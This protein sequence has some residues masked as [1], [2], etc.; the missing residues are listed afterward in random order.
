MMMIVVY[1]GR[2]SILYYMIPPTSYILIENVLLLNN[3]KWKMLTNKYQWNC[4]P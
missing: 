1:D 3:R 4:I 2:E